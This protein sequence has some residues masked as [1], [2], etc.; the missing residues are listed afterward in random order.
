MGQRMFVSVRPSE[1]ALEDLEGFLEPR[2]SAAPFP[3]VRST[4]WHLTLAFMASVSDRALGPLEERLAEAAARHTPFATS[5]GGAGVFP[6]PLRA[7]VLWLGLAEGAP[8]LAGIAGHARTACE[9]SGAPVDGQAFVPHLTLAR[10]RRPLEATRWLRVLD[11]YRGPAWTVESID[12][13]ASHLRDGR[14][15]RHEV[16]ASYPLTAP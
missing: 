6:D 15:P 8:E 16:I 14:H 11:T 1:A 3:F 13:V 10:L 4:Q 2:A 9:V 12:L 5:L 7:K